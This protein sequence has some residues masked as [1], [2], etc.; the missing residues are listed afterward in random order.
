MSRT[1]QCA[2]IVC[3]A[4]GAL[5]RARGADGGT[6]AE[7]V[8]QASAEVRD[9]EALYRSSELASERAA[10]LELILQ[11]AAWLEQAGG[12]KD[13]RAD[14]MLALARLEGF[15]R[16]APLRYG[17]LTNASGASSVELS[18]RR[19]KPGELPE[20]LRALEKRLIFLNVQNAS[21]AAL[22]LPGGIVAEF[23]ARF[24]ETRREQVKQGA[25]LPEE[26]Q[27]L[28][29]LFALPDRLA[30]S[31]EK[32]CFVLLPDTSDPLEALGIRIKEESQAA[33]AARTGRILFPECTDPD[34]LAAARKKAAAIEKEILAEREAKLA[35]VKVAPKPPVA[36][37]EPPKD[38]APEKPKPEEKSPDGIGS[39]ERAGSDE[40]IQIRMN[41]GSVFFK[42]ETLLVRKEKALVGKVRIP[43]GVVY[44][45]DKQV[46]WVKI[47][48]GDRNALAGG[49]LHHPE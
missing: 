45:E 21:S 19:P 33:D 18:A 38:P 42:N 10:A 31:E 17:Y 25:E 20:R 49:T 24:A 16:P 3:L 30:P 28:A 43:D 15:Q 27:P 46:Y 6:L 14:Q 5:A 4:S 44:V 41:A 29:P 35:Q 32:Q 12:M 48:E 23:R 2:L 7:R 8:R 36:Q 26:L 9:L 13:A 47:V 40:I 22:E 1:L 39:V 11:R 34:G 37:P